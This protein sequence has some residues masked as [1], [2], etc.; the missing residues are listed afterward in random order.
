M[1]GVLH[2][3]T[4]ESSETAE[5][6]MGKANDFILMSEKIDKWQNI[7]TL[8]LNLPPLRLAMGHATARSLKE[9]DRFE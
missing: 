4:G 3:G 5:G 9:R 2:T 1:T 7:G 6:Q 8:H